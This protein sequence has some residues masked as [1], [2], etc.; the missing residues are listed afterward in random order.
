ML[1]VFKSYIVF[2]DAYV[3]RRSLMTRGKHMKR[4]DEVEAVEL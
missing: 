4:V 3:S 1:R 2:G